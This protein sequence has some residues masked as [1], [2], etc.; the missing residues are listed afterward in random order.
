MPARIARTTYADMYGPTTG[1]RVRLADTDLIVEVERDLT[2]YGEEVKFGGGKVIRDGMG[3]SQVM[4]A[5]G[6]VE[7][8]VDA[9]MRGLEA[10]EARL[11][12]RVDDRA[13]AE[14]ADVAAPDR[15]PGLADREPGGV[16]KSLRRRLERGSHRTGGVEGGIDRTERT[17]GQRPRFGD[18]HI[19]QDPASLGQRVRHRLVVANRADGL[20]GELVARHCEGRI[21][22]TTTRRR[23]HVS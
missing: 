13:H 21:V 10:A 20:E 15:E 16:G 1:D 4:R 2:T 7:H 18:Q 14:A 11:V 19:A 3:Q 5:G 17:L 8:V 23:G 6:A 22:P 9:A 12:G